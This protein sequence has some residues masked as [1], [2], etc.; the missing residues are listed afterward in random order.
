MSADEYT[1]LGV[2]YCYLKKIVLREPADPTTE[3]W[4]K[5]GNA[6]PADIAQS[7]G[8]TRLDI[9]VPFYQVILYNI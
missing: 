1:V 7:E 3:L 8:A 4:S 6:S 9:N 2:S 5:L